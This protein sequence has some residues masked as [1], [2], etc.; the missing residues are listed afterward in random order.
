[1]PSRTSKGW[2]RR[3]RSSTRLT[4]GRDCVTRGPAA[5]AAGFVVRALLP[6]F[7]MAYYPFWI[8][9]SQLL[10]ILAF[11]VFVIVYAPMLLSARVDGRD[12]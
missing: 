8:A 4:A 1:M 2:S 3:S 5:F 10:W 7:T 9:A 12:G 6:L 11:A